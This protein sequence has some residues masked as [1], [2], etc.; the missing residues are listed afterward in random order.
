L[1]D[2]NIRNNLNSASSNNEW[3]GRRDLNPGRQRGRLMLTGL[4]LG[5]GCW[6]I[7]KS[8]LPEIC[9]V[10]QRSFSIAFWNGI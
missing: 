8:V 1:G 3:C 5:N 7:I 6:K 2:E 10:T 9:S 4:F